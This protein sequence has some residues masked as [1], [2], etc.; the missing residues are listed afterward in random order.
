MFGILNFR[1]ASKKTL[2][3]IYDDPEMLVE[4]EFAN[5]TNTIK[6]VWVEMACVDL[7][8]DAQTEYKIVTHDKFFR[9]EFDTDG[10]IIFYLQYTFGFKLYKRP[11]S[12]EVKN[13]W[14]LYI[15]YS[16]IN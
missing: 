11:T 12:R 7:E 15:D 9:M 10:G 13:S 4:I 14:E 2:K 8:L 5:R 6:H 1:K 3:E 16:D